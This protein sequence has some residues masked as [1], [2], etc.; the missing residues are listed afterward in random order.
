MKH[1]QTLGIILKRINYGEAD[2]IIT[3]LTNSHGKITF[4]ARGVRKERSKLA[5]G[6][7]LFSIS[8][9]SFILGKR[10]IGTLVSTRLKVHYKKIVTDINRTNAAYNFLKILDKATEENCEPQYFELLSQTLASLDDTTISLDLVETWFIVQLLKLQGHEPNLTTGTNGKKLEAGQT[11]N[12]D[13][14]HMAFFARDTGKY[15]D[16]HIKLM[17]LLLVK[18][19]QKISKLENTDKIIKDCLELLKPMTNQFV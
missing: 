8:N 1:E 6:I 11:Y 5:G 4:M 15:T 7:E 13:Y 12:F 16:N 18:S 10:D 14:E 9:I 17:R 3:V 2:R 19:P